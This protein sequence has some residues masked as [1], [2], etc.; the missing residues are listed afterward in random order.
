MG[1]TS[2]TQSR[3]GVL[4]REEEGEAAHQGDLPILAETMVPA[5]E[6]PR[7]HADNSTGSD[8][9]IY[10]GHQ[11]G[12]YDFIIGHE[13]V[14]TIVKAGDDVKKWKVGDRVIVPFS[15]SCGECCAGGNGGGDWREDSGL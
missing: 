5:A 13:A 1:E 11:P 14:G 15:T 2:R 7:P 6:L 9:H 3:E 8:L 4:G 12:P 10:R